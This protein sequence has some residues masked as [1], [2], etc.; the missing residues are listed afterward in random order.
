PSVRNAYTILSAM[1][2]SSSMIRI[3]CGIGAPDYKD[4]SAN[5]KS[6]RSGRDCRNPDAKEGNPDTS[7]CTGYRQSM[8]V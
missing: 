5:Q 6:R 3:F 1:D 8:P 4:R 7:L 2:G